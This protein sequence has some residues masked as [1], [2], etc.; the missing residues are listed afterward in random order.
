MSAEDGFHEM[1]QEQRDLY[2]YDNYEQRS[3]F[4]NTHVGSLRLVFLE[5]Q[6]VHQTL[7]LFRFFLVMWPSEDKSFVFMKI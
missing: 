6:G 4:R 2:D 5:L 7:P 3:V 1:T